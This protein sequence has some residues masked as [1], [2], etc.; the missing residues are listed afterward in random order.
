MSDLLPQYATLYCFNQTMNNWTMQ[1]AKVKPCKICT[2]ALS[3][4]KED[5]RTLRFSDLK[6]VY[7]TYKSA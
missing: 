2:V 6:N 5:N 4:V 7:I 1:F 3:K